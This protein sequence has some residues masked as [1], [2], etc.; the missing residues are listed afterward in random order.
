LKFEKR[1]RQIRRQRRSD[2]ESLYYI[3]E[4]DLDRNAIFDSNDGWFPQLRIGSK[5]I[6]DYALKYGDL[7]VGIEVKKGFPDL[8]H[9]DQ[10]ARYSKFFDAIFLAYPSDAAAEALFLSESKAVN[11]QIGILALAL[12]RTH[13][14]RRAGVIKRTSDEVW[15]NAFDEKEYWKDLGRKRK[16]FK[17]DDDERL[18]ASALMSKCIWTKVNKSGKRTREACR[19]NI[20]LSAWRFVATLYALS[21]AKSIYCMHPKTEVDDLFFKKMKWAY[22]NWGVPLKAG[23]VYSREYGTRLTLYNLTEEMDLLRPELEKALEN[24]LGKTDWRRIQEI[25]DDLKK[26][27]IETQKTRFEEFFKL[28]A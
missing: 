9:F 18:T 4:R 14:V 3:L 24:E 28:T 11:I 25:V 13:V 10:V 8:K 20:P 2:E 21:N 26:E 1:R 15:K 6:I 12:Y 19:I 5:G 23:F 22:M 7:L 17:L 27:H 16:E